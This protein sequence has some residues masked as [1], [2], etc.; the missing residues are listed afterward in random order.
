MI[1]IAGYTLTDTDKRD[2]AVEAFA[3]MV[4]RARKF[5]GCLDLSI[6]ADSVDSDRV[7]IF[8]CWRDEKSWKAWREV[9]NTPKVKL[10]KANRRER[11]VKL[12]RSE[13]A[14]EPF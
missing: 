3:P 7:N 1:I 6:G 11:F 5:D 14:E 13:K 9:A 2:A 10:P 8:E 12:Y 4:K